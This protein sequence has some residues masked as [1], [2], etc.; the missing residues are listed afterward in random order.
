[1]C[2]RYFPQVCLEEDMR[3]KTN[4][5]RKEGNY[6]TSLINYQITTSSEIND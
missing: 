3:I 2:V 6:D 1:M 4:D 5:C